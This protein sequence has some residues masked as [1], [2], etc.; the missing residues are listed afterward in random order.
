MSDWTSK[1]SHL[2]SSNTDS[3]VSNSP[4]S[5]SGYFMQTVSND[6][7]NKESLNHQ[8][9]HEALYAAFRI[10]VKSLQDLYAGTARI[11]ED[12]NEALERFCIIVEHLVSHGFRGDRH[13]RHW[14]RRDIWDFVAGLEELD[15]TAGNQKLI[16]NT[17]RD[18]EGLHSGMG[19]FRAWLRLS[20]MEQSLSRNWHL[21][22]LQS[23]RIK[24]F[25]DDSA[26]IRSDKCLP[27]CELL[28]GLD[29]IQFNLFIKGDDLEA[30]STVIDWN[31][32]LQE[33]YNYAH[34]NTFTATLG[35]SKNIQRSPESADPGVDIETLIK[36]KSYVE[37]QNRDA[38][39]RLVQVNANLK[40]SEEDNAIM[41]QR[42]S[43]LE[44]SL[45]RE[46]VKCESI[47]TEL[48]LE[49]QYFKESKH[50]ILSLQQRIQAMN[51]ELEEFRKL[52][53]DAHE[54]KIKTQ[55]VLKA[56]QAHLIHAIKAKEQYKAELES[57]KPLQQDSI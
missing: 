16:F 56:T 36:Q 5:N 11:V 3:P 51:E 15:G 46:A 50:I 32:L 42:I 24:D 52:A 2:F 44:A 14:R 47:Y 45:N 6:I 31:F 23:D 34:F 20:L 8:V 18:L 40:R 26:L 38:Q 35:S 57:A 53:L 29:F 25:Y 10:A 27:I 48:E 41:K 7:Q 54:A 21:L 37:E 13:G 55:E 1:L 4:F 22:M 43:Q 9:E 33:G 17:I 28:N 49:R 12:G 30:R 39:K 19:K